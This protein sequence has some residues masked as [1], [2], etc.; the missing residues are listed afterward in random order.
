MSGELFTRGISLKIQISVQNSDFGPR[1]YLQPA[2][3]ADCFE[4]DALC[5]RSGRY[6]SAHIGRLARVLRRKF[7]E[8]AGRAGDEENIAGRGWR[9]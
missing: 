5:D 6:V 1:K 2:F 7:S 3:L 8:R 9:E 4:D